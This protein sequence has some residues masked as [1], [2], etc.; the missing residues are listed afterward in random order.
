M[1]EEAREPLHITISAG[2]GEGRTSLS[3]F[4]AALHDAGV[5]DFNLVRLSSVIP[6][7]SRLTVGAAGDRVR[8]GFGDLLYAV[9]AAA[10]A[11]EPG[12]QAWAGLTWSRRKDGSGAGL[13][14]EHA[15]PT[16]EQLQT[17][18]DETL[19][20][21][22]ARRGHAFEKEEQLLSGATCERSPVCAL[23]LASYHTSDWRS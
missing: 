16:R 23:V 6:P 1:H 14:V 2:R 10:W 17:L 3:A 11:S 8:G 22:G 15:A 20:D 12:A 13:F 21:L 9:Y 18:L 4:D 5:A 7:G 19:A